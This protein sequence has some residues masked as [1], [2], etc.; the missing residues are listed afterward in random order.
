[1]NRV[2]ELMQEDALALICGIF[3]VDDLR[4]VH[5]HVGG[6]TD[7]VVQVVEALRIKTLPAVG[8][9]HFHADAKD[10]PPLK[11]DCSR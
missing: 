3:E 4:A 1:M 11:I 5:F 7:R 2:S 9:L 6:I 10:T 8:I